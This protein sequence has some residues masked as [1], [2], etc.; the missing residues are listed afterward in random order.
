MMSR[1]RAFSSP[2]VLPPSSSTSQIEVR[3][4]DHSFEGIATNVKL[5]LKLIQDQNEAKDNDARKTQRVAG[6][7]SIIDDVKSRIQKSQNGG[8]KAE[9]RRCNTDLKPHAPPK[10]KRP[11]E[12]ITDEKEKLRRSLSA[13]LAARKSLEIMCS[14]LGKEK[15]IIATEL[16]RKVQEFHGMEEHINDLRVQNE[17][18]LAK[19]KACAAEHKE[20][21]CGGEEESDTYGNAALQERN[22]EL[23]EQLLK[24]LDG[25]RSLKR[26]IKAAHK[27]NDAMHLAMEEI[28]MDIQD[29][30]DRIRCLKE[31]IV[32]GNADIEEELLALEHLFESCYM[33]VSEHEQKKIEKNK[34]EVNAT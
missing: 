3:P 2:S 5:L 28:G 33:K 24:S 23:S 15:E 14:S 11:H 20:N 30:L 32:A 22:K 27:E 19:V 18:L 13:S 16:A 34:A 9:L 1:I 17:K 4:E 21:K 8:R 6:M 26:K 10:D 25:C 31:G 12:P 29:G 7:I